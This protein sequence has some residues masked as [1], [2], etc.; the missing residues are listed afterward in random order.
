MLFEVA[1]QLEFLLTDPGETA[2]VTG[3]SP[4]QYGNGVALCFVSHPF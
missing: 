3:G 4:M 1:F 2:D